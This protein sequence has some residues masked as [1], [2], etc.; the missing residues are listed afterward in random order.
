ME[1]LK[2]VLLS[3]LVDFYLEDGKRK[4]ASDMF[5]LSFQSGDALCRKGERE[6]SAFCIITEGLVKAT[7][8]SFGG[9]DFEDMV[10]G[11]GRD[12]TS[13]G[14]PSMVSDEPMPATIRAMTDGTTLVLS[15]TTVRRALG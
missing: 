13:F 7:D 3:E 1:L 2:N 15:K 8:L 12:Q 6:S 4:L 11:P 10:I 14:W 5:T 9:R